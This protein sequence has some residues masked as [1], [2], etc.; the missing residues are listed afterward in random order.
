MA[1]KSVRNEPD[2]TPVAPGSRNDTLHR[3]AYGRLANH[4]DNA[5]WIRDDLYQR[6]HASGLKDSELETIRCSVT[7][8]LGGGHA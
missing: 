8:Q 1:G 3:W 7:R 6:G 4:P 2:M 5:M